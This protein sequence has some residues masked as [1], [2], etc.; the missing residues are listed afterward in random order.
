MAQGID[1]LLVWS[2]P[3]PWSAGGGHRPHQLLLE[4][5]VENI[6]TERRH[7]M[8]RNVGDRL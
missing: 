8:A 6:W 7:T 5:L 2:Y 4:E 3:L 1:R